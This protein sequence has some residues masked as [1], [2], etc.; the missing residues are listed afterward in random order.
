MNI[1]I[2]LGIAVIVIVYLAFR[3]NNMRTKLSFLFII[4]GVM[5]LLLLF[6]LASGRLDLSDLG[7]A[8]SSMKGFFLSHTF[9]CAEVAN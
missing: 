8:S 3:W 4:F 1:L 6:V 2:L 5:F 7:Q 9:Q